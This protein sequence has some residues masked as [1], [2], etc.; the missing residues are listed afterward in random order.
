MTE[1][2]PKN[3]DW[4]MDVVQ[5]FITHLRDDLH[6]EMNADKFNYNTATSGKD[7]Y[8]QL[9]KLQRSSA[10]AIIAE[11]SIS[12][13]HKIAQDAV[14]NHLFIAKV[15]AF[16]AEDTLNRYAGS[17]NTNTCWGC[18]KPSHGFSDEAG[19]IIF[20][21]KDKPGISEAAD[22]KRKEFN[23]KL[24]KKKN[25]GR[26]KRDVSTL[27]NTALESMS[28]DEIK[29]L[30][31]GHHMGKK[32]K[33]SVTTFHI[34][35]FES[36]LARDSKPLLP[37]SIEANLPHIAL[38]IGQNLETASISILVAYDTCA[39]NN[40]GYIGHHLPI[41]EKFPQVVKSL[42]Y[43]ADKYSP[44]VLSGIV[45]DTEGKSTVKPTT[46]LPDIIEYWLPFRTKEGHRTTLKIALGHHVS[47]N[48]IIGMPMIKPAKLSLDLTDNVVKAGVLDT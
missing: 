20:P 48:T 24:K 40:V 18:G 36:N 45:T 28:G 37:I 27:L 7:A 15:N 6:Q 9:M 2:F 11:E 4:E 17:N 46:T 32:V 38:P 21:D 44:L 3:Q 16:V 12:R 8:S 41:T 22:E 19:N 5:H 30:I 29:A 14:S 33:P 47:V 42:T 1:F 25:E 35:V 13:V 26:K 23:D 43:A 34:Q 31:S 39:A 10:A